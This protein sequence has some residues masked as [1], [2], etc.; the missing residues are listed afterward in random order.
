MAGDIANPR[1]SSFARAYFP[2][3]VSARHR[4]WWDCRTKLS[5]EQVAFNN[6]GRRDLEVRMKQWILVACL[7][8]NTTWGQSTMHTVVPFGFENE[9]GNSNDG[10]FESGGTFQE[11][12]RASYLATQWQ[13][14]VALTE[15]AF[16][17]SEGVPLSLQATVPRLEIRFSTSS[18]SP[19]NMSLFYSANRGVDE[20]T[21]FLHD[22]VPLSGT[23]GQPINPFDIRVTFDRPFVYDPKIGNLLMYMNA[24][25]ISGRGVQVDAQG[26]ASLGASPAGYVGTTFG[27]N[28][29]APFVLV[30]QFSFVAVPE[31]SASELALIA[32][33]AIIT[34]IKRKWYV[35]A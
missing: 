27:Q 21:V 2:D 20:T 35:P 5:A 30:T 29:I 32:A 33:I 31:P 9:N 12:F 22:N 23:A 4:L 19:E 3:G 24:S 10:I 26:Y 17:V 7:S 11:L 16:R 14:P 25:G 28:Q 6:A 15:V 1:K 13:T 8:V 18:R 34:V